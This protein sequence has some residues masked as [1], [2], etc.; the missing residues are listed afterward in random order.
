MSQLGDD[1]ELSMPQLGRQDLVL[2]TP[3]P[4]GVISYQY[5]PRIQAHNYQCKKIGHHPQP[6]YQNREKLLSRNKQYGVTVVCTFS[7]NNAV[8]M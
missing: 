8:N 4:I 3:L 5:S 7:L 6:D 2:S 1:L